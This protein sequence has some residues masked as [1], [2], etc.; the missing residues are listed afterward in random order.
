MITLY[1]FELSGNCHKVRLLLSLLGVTYHSHI[2]NGNARE[3][4]SPEFLAMNPHGQVPVLKDGDIIIRDS[5]AI[6]VYLARAYGLPHWL[7]TDAVPAAR[8][9]AWLSTAAHE[10]ARG[11]NA[12]RLHYKFGRAINLEEATHITHELLHMLDKKLTKQEW[13]ATPQISIADI[14]VYPYIAL[15]HE[16][17]VDLSP[18][19]A[20]GKWLTRIEAQPGYKSMPGIHKHATAVF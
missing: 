18:F 9:N 12:L 10:V 17:Q 13:L 8:I 7:P 3:H 1:E 16:G 20:V 6:L 14:A 19:P 4:K 11:P 5:Q 2:V 15:A